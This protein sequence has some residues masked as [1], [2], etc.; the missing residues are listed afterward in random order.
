MSRS[1][2]Q[3]LWTHPYMITLKPALLPTSY[4]KTQEPPPTFGALIANI[5]YH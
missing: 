1:K 3:K 5:V 4:D 2:E